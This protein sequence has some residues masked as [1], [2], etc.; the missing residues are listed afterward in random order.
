MLRRPLKHDD[1]FQ[2]NV[3]YGK[4]H[5]ILQPGRAGTHT[6][7]NQRLYH[8]FRVTEILMCDETASAVN[9]LNSRNRKINVCVFHFNQELASQYRCTY[10]VLFRNE[11]DNIF[12]GGYFS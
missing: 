8:I 12:V 3:T 1:L 4:K 5:T 7:H 6:T 11:S 9:I 10:L 2:H